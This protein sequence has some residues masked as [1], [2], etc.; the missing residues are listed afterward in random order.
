MGYQRRV[1]GESISCRKRKMSEVRVHASF[2]VNNVE[3]FLLAT[4][5]MITATQLEEGCIHYDL[6]KENGSEANFA[7]IETW[8]SADDLERHSKSAHVKEFQA[9]QKENIGSVVIK[10]FV[11]A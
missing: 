3:E 8:T 4:K 2:S 11:K 9:N 5:K 10:T 6:Y 7:M 1:H